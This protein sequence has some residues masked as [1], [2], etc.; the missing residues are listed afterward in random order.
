MTPNW[1][2][3]FRSAI[4]RKGRGLDRTA[5]SL[6]SLQQDRHGSADSRAGAQSSRH[7]RWTLA[8]TERFGR[9]ITWRGIHS[10][11]MIL[12]H[13]ARFGIFLR[14]ISV[15]HSHSGILINFL[16]N[17]EHS[18]PRFRQSVFAPDGKPLALSSQLMTG[19]P[20]RTAALSAA[21][22]QNRIHRLTTATIAQRNRL[23][24]RTER[25]EVRASLFENR[26]A[27]PTIHPLLSQLAES[28][29]DILAPVER[30]HRRLEQRPFLKPRDAAD[31]PRLVAA[32]EDLTVVAKSRP[33]VPAA[34]TS[35][36]SFSA[37]PRV[38]TARPE[39]PVNIGQI[40]DAVLQQLDRRLVA[41]RE[42]MGKI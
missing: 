23:I 40:T 6:R 5:R 26:G 22:V 34:A 25:F 11:N 33:R 3:H 27:H 18:E 9:R 7:L 29:S 39:F 15:E 30:K 8:I 42:R 31:E 35:E 12:S 19:E 38:S 28:G 20:T 41:A 16:R 10:E 2:L 4:V 24:E 21:C 37:K 14:R 17:G 1:G 36:S 32:P 13:P